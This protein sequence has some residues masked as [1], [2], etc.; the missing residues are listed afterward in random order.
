[1]KTEPQSLS[2][3]EQAS[4][5][6]KHYHRI[7]AESWAKESSEVRAEV[8]KIYDNEDGAD[9]DEENEM[10]GSEEDDDERSSLLRQQ[11]WVQQFRM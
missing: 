4:R 7:R 9:E 11:Q 8:L 6:M 5:T 10:D 2:Q 3:P 1:M